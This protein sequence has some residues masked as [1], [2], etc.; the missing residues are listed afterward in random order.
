MTRR[1]ATI[2]VVGT[3]ILMPIVFLS[4]RQLDWYNAVRAGSSQHQAYLAIWMG[5]SLLLVI[6]QVVCFWA[7]I[8]PQPSVP[9]RLPWY[10]RVIFAVLSVSIALTNHLLFMLLFAPRIH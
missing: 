2:Y 6:L 7:A 10:V 3:A 1:F 5:A 8:R 4:E 9:N